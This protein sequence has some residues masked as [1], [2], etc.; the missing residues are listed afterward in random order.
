MDDLKLAF[1]S[2]SELEKNEFERFLQLRKSKDNRKDTE[3]FLS[4]VKDEAISK[5]SK[6]ETDRV[7]QNRVRL[8][9][10]LAEFTVLK[11]MQDETMPVARL[12]SYV[13]LARY[14][15]KHRLQ[16]SG[17]KYLNKAEK[18]AEDSQHFFI[19]KSIYLLKLENSHYDFAEDIS[20]LLKK[21]K[22][23][24]KRLEKNE[25]LLVASN[26]IKHFLNQDKLKPGK[27]SLKERVENSLKKFNISIND[28]E[29]PSQ[30]HSFLGILRNSHLVNQELKHFQILIIEQ[31]NRLNKSQLFDQYTH[32]YKL[33]ILYMIAHACFR[34]RDFNN[35]KNYL[36]ELNANILKYND[37]YYT[38]YYPKY[39]AMLSNIYSL[40]GDNEKAIE[41]TELI[42][43]NKKLKIS[44]KDSYNLNLNLVVF[45]FY[46]RKFKIANRFFL[47]V[48]H[49]DETLVKKLGVEWVMRKNLIHAILQYELGND[50]VCLSIIK[51]MEKKYSDTLRMDNYQRVRSY[52]SFL[53]K[54]IQSP[55]EFNKID[56]YKDA[57]H[58]LYTKAFDVEEYKTMAFYGWLKSKA[59]K[60]DFY[61]TMKELIQQNLY[62]ISYI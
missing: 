48:P 22:E 40:L 42:L 54:Y 62:D 34:N 45:N 3:L 37:E 10:S 50:D 39:I 24:N 41:I 43:K 31:Y 1:R 36:E 55:T 11:E 4:L 60:K 56:F 26:Y 18:L 14:L 9:T 28:F 27:N 29:S 20:E 52:L 57:E 5:E 59:E 30:V 12:V 58:T 44:M 17:W 61:L 32:Y 15:F 16:K 13:S 6:Q 53:K 47:F 2:F 38:R 35:T 7:N 46:K 51:K 19:L 33:D 8:W 23:N 49:S 21:I 25:K